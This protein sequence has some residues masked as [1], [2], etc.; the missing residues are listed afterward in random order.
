MRIV[1]AP[2]S[3]KGSLSATKVADAIETGI[4]NI[5]SNIFVDKVPMAD[6]GEGTVEALIVA[7]GGHII[8]KCVTGPLGEPVN[9]FYGILGDGVTGVVELAAAS[10]ILLVPKEKRN[11]M[12][13]NTFGTGELIKAAIESGCK[14]LIVGIGGS[15]TNDGGT[16]LLQALGVRFLDS[17]KR[18]LGFGGQ[19][20]GLIHSIDVSGLYKGLQGI[21]IEVAC[22]VSNPIC[23]YNGAA[24]IYGPQKGATDQMIEKM[25]KGLRNYSNKL[26]E[27]CGKD[28]R[29][30]PGGGAAGG[31][32][33]GI[34]ALLDARLKPG[35][36][37]MIEATNLDHKI[38]QAQLVITGE[39]KTDNQTVF[40]KVPSG[41]AKLAKLHGVPAVCVSGGVGE[42]FEQLYEMGITSVFGITN[43]PMT[44]EEAMLNA[45]VLVM[46]AT[47]NIIRLFCH[48]ARIN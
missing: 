25:D 27:F 34:V 19:I 18:E 9:S 31:V 33:G 38:R 39:G 48:S 2:D 47:E 37:I 45:H 22:D 41:I 30:L 6:G 10:G 46:K 21:E 12:L 24:Y 44:L 13:T 42:G 3:Y 43:R 15:S 36:D 8:E 14:K 17:E 7:T 5:D 28:V 32:G 11:P 20:L 16:G 26:I 23:G 4:K 1:V 40:G 29:N 35:I